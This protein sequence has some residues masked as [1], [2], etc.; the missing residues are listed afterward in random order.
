LT[1]DKRFLLHRVDRDRDRL[2]LEVRPG[3][4]KGGKCNASWNKGFKPPMREAGS[5]NDLDDTVD[6]NQ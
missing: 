6:S 5:P 4:H 3:E 2:K 1:I